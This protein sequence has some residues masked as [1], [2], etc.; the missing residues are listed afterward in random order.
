MTDT[1][2]K[3]ELLQKLRKD[4]A[5]SLKDYENGRVYTTEQVKEYLKL[6]EDA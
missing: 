3:E 6:T 2:T 5:N 1:H 4:M